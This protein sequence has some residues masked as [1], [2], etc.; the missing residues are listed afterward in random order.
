ME[1]YKKNEYIQKL[2]FNNNKHAPGR[3]ESPTLQG[4]IGKTKD[5][6]VN[7]HLCNSLH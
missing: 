1:I 4:L 7:C 3:T 2:G 6:T 5:H